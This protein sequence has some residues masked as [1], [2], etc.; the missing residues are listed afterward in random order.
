M[1]GKFVFS[2]IISKTLDFELTPV[3][4]ETLLAWSGLGQTTPKSAEE[5]KKNIVNFYLE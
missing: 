2:A 4:E 1:S 5:I 3:H